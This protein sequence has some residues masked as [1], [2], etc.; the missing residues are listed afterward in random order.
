MIKIIKSGKK[1]FHTACP[2]CGCEFT[3]E[4][5]DLNGT[6]YVNCPECNARISHLA[7]DLKPL[8]VIYEDGGTIQPSSPFIAPLIKAKDNNQFDNPCRTCSYYQRLKA[9][10]IY[11]GDTPCTWCQYNPYRVTCNTVNTSTN[12]NTD[13]TIDTGETEGGGINFNNGKN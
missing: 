13:V 6:D 4:V 1:E 3:Y 7:R 9:G 11:V 12:T 8:E 5:E 10:E 2:C